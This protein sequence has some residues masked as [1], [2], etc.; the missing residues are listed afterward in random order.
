MARGTFSDGDEQR[1]VVGQG[2]PGLLLAGPDRSKDPEH[3]C[4]TSIVK[5]LARCEVYT[6]QACQLATLV[7]ANA[8]LVSVS[9]VWRMQAY[10]RRES[11]LL[12]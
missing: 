11:L 7:L 2:R 9:A 3:V 6:V 12:W 1:P 5:V 10:P 8:G 4:T